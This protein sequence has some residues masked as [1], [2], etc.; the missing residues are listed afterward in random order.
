MDKF[1]DV[2]G[3]CY[4]MVCVIILTVMVLIV[5]FNAGMRYF[6]HSGFIATE[7][8]L[9]YLF[10]YLTFLGIAHVACERGHISVTILT[11]FLPQKIRTLVY[12]L[13]YA[14]AMWVV[15]V[16]IDGAIM[17]YGESETSTGQVTGLP[18]RVIISVMI[19]GAVGLFAFLLRDFVL[20]IKALRS[21]E[22]FPPR[23]VDEDVQKAIESMDK[24]EGAK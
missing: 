3:R 15:W 2:F 12:V 6:M 16:L 18:F 22:E 20:G 9:R 4:R 8:V 23:L 13:G 10:I 14:A 11:D 21:G 19:F 7:E 17:Y 5:F 24:D 1:F